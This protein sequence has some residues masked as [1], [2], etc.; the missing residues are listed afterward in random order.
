[1]LLLFVK[2]ELNCNVTNA[3]LLLSLVRMDLRLDFKLPF[4]LKPN[5]RHCIAI[6]RSCRENIYLNTGKEKKKQRIDSIR[7]P[8]Q[9]WDEYAFIMNARL[10]RGTSRQEEKQI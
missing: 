10:M 2:M 7:I 6:Q 5:S 1:M 4:Y 8:R 3:F 9:S